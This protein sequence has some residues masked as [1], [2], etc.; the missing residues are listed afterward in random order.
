MQQN[1]GRIYQKHNYA[2]FDRKRFFLGRK[3]IG[4]YSL[5][6]GKVPEIE[7]SFGKSARKSVREGSWTFV[8]FNL[9]QK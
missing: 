8:F 1:Y 5:S 9:V 3:C 4:L 7:E 2:K 6:V